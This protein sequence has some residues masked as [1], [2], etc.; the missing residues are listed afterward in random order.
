MRELSTIVS[1]RGTRRSV[2]GLPKA[3]GGAVYEENLGKDEEDAA[4]S[5]TRGATRGAAERGASER[6]AS[7]RVATERGATERGATKRGA[8]SGYTVRL[9]AKGGCG[10]WDR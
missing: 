8:I 1:S 6:G 7:E 4:N 3:A 9:W 2:K 5:Y 10:E